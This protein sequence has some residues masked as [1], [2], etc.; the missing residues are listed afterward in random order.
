MYLKR[1]KPIISITFSG[2]GIHVK[3]PPRLATRS[4]AS[5]FTLR[6]GDDIQIDQ[7]KGE[8]FYNTEKIKWTFSQKTTKWQIWVDSLIGGVIECMDELFGLEI[9]IFVFGY[10][11]M[12]RGISFRSTHR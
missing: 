11:K 8:M 4:T 2:K 9:P 6:N 10:T 12:R 3:L 7:A 1:G 5:R